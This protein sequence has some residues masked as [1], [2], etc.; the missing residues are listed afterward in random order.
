MVG[1]LLTVVFEPDG[2]RVFVSAGMTIL[3]AARRTGVGL[4]SECGGRG[5]CGKCRVIVR[6]Q[7][8]VSDITDVERKHLSKVEIECGYR[9]ACQTRVLKDVS[10]M[11][12]LESRLESIKILTSGF[13]RIVNLDPMVRKVYVALS[14]PSLTDVKPDFER[15]SDAVGVVEI[16]YDVL[17]ILPNILHESNWSVTVVL[18]G[19]RIIG[20]ESGDTANEVYGLAVDIGTSKV[21]CHLMD[22]KRG[23]TVGV[24]SMENPQVIHGEDIIS[25][26]AYASSDSRNLHELQK[27]VID[28]INN[29]LNG[30]CG[31]YGVDSGR[32]YELLFVGNTAMH[33]IF[34]GIQ[35]KYLALSPYT[36]AIKR[37]I[38]VK[39][40]DLSININPN[41]IVSTLPLIAGFVGSDAVADI[42]ATGIHE[43]DGNALLI[44]IGTNTE[45]VLGGRDG[46]ICCSCASGPAF[47]GAHI[48]HG[49]KAVS[50]AIER[51]KIS[52]GLEVEYSTVDGSKPRGLCGSAIIDVVAELF[53]HGVIDRQGRFNKNIEA[54]RLRRGE[55]GI[56]FII[57]WAS[58][59]GVGYDITVTQKDIREVQLAKA[60]IYSGCSILMG[61]KGVTEKDIDRI[62]IA[63][64]FGNYINP[65]NAKVIG[66][67]PDVPIEKI[68]FVG[69]AAIAG[70]KMVL[71]SK[72]LR[73]QA[74]S[75]LKLINYHELAADPNF[76]NE[77]MNALPIP[78]ADINRFPSVKELIIHP[79]I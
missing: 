51:V 62:F 16:D 28:C 27:L 75:I 13:E 68:M 30:L 3:E 25:R 38:N 15:L 9:L 12:P 58:E 4:R 70:A 39:A 56:E 20:V 59:T 14:K 49:M 63:G 47:E 18:Y 19:D 46:M 6:D 53:R 43:F 45:I 73:M 74:E 36:P 66:L 34:L 24:G 72:D 77:F 79:N 33:H 52:R 10:I 61:K 8:A 44:D 2:R 64:A 40:K 57:A 32:I 65:E 17:K 41:G 29:I 11:I 76:N 7:H 50:G 23:E 42:L 48:K 67:I 69:N 54:Q 21:V 35:P 5:V 22:L 78:H 71:L 55:S 26:I 31:K 1:K 37:P 60:A